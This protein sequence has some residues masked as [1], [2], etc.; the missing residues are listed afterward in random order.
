MSAPLSRRDVLTGIVASSALLAGL[1]VPAARADSPRE[2][3]LA[4]L[5]E[6]HVLNERPMNA[7]T[8]L[9]LLGSSRTPNAHHFVRNNGLV[10]DLAWTG[11]ASEYRLT[12][13]GEVH[14]PLTLSLEELK[15]DFPVHRAALVLECGGNG[16]AGFRPA[17]K[18][19]PWTLGAVGCAD[20][21]GVLLKDVLAKARVRTS[22]VYL[23]YE[24][25]DRHLSG[26][27]DKQPISRGCPI[28]K[29]LDG[30]S[31]LAWSMNGEPLPAVHGFPLRLLIPGYPASASGKWVT[32]LW[33][34][35]QVH[36]G[37][38]MNG[39]SYRVPAHPVAPG[40]E[41]PDSDMVII[42]EMPVKSVLTHPL[43]GHSMKAGTTVEVRGHAWSGAGDIGAVHLSLDFGATWT[44]T[45]LDPAA[46]RWAWQDWRSALSIPTAGH[47]E[48]WVRATDE[49]GVQQPMVVPGWNPKGYLNNAMQRIA[50][51]VV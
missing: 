43:T 2:V 49:R 35:A 19:N 31:M 33:I 20:Y 44:Q 37:A 25:S 39:Q 46:N 34:R 15:R 5:R 42:E 47:Y 50:L 1:R 9:S 11:D 36:D 48:L 30:H 45:T 26:S 40:T 23:A 41:V 10:P 27:T 3:A 29:A 21:E 17:A 13:D 32:R 8:P 7:E 18:G 24:A 51:E 28:G 4:S 12:I 22:A 6:L 38:K 14:S 16:R